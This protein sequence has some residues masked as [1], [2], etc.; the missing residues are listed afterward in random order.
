MPRVCRK[1][2]SQGASAEGRARS[3]DR[4]GSRATEKVWD[5]EHAA[6][7]NGGVLSTA[8]NLVFQGA[9]TANSRHT[10]QRLDR[11]LVIRG[12]GRNRRATDHVRSRQRPV[13][14]VARRLGGC[15]PLLT[16]EIARKGSLSGSNGR[17]LVFRLDG[18]RDCRR[19]SAPN[20][21]F[22]RRRRS[23]PIRL[24]SRLECV[25]TSDFAVD[26][27][28]AAPFRGVLPDLRHSALLANRE[29]WSRIVRDGALESR[30]MVGSGAR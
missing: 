4:L 21:P 15:V 1:T 28:A 13:R 18:E 25:C 23:S 3:F 11:N 27:T 29:G 5:V 30:G 12:T 19:K 22:R 20:R 6:A 2:R 9:A 14:R 24:R 8:G 7:W 17:I 10:R 16:G 26:V